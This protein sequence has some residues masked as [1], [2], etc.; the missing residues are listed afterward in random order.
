MEVWI[1]PNPGEHSG[2]TFQFLA[3][4]TGYR[5]YQAFPR[6]LLNPDTV[7]GWDGAYRVAHRNPRWVLA[8]RNR[9]TT[10]RG[11]PRTHGD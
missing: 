5:A 3:N 10:R 2:V 1:D 9:N 6:G 8:L 7:Y 4:S 11:R